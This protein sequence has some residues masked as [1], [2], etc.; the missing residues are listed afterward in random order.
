MS[1]YDTTRILHLWAGKKRFLSRTTVEKRQSTVIALA[2][3]VLAHSL[4]R[5][6]GIEPV[7]TGFADLRV[8]R[9]AT[10]AC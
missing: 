10:G 8:S 2:N 9:F 7:N 4:E 5:R 1:H 3:T 6:T